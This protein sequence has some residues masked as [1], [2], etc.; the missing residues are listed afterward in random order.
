[1]T[2][3][4]DLCSGRNDVEGPTAAPRYFSIHITNTKS[5][6]EVMKLTA[7]ANRDWYRHLFRLTYRGCRLRPKTG[8]V[9]GTSG[10]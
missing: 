4:C 6:N 9:E 5:I 8:K 7:A 2:K 10:N 3:Q 1:M